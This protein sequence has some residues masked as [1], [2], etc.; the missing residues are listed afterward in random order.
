MQSQ[1][2]PECGHEFGKCRKM[3]TL[4]GDPWTGSPQ[5]INVQLPPK[6]DENWSKR[7]LMSNPCIQR[8][9][10]ARVNDGGLKIF[11]VQCHAL[12]IAKEQSFQYKSLNSVPVEL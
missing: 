5:P 2:S 3:S 8:I 10:K 1:I 6:A 11:H 12:Q 9:M 7:F 4:E